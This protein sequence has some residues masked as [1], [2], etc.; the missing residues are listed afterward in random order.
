[1]S[2]RG[3][4]ALLLLA[5]FAAIAVA[6]Q[7]AISLGVLGLA[8]SALGVKK[9]DSVTLDAGVGALQAAARVVDTAWSSPPAR[10][11]ELNPVT[12]GAVDDLRASVH[13]VAVGS[14]TLTPLAEAA[15]LAVG[16]DGE[17]PLLSGSTIDTARLPD[18]A[19][20]VAALHADLQSTSDALAAVPGSGP[21]GW[22]L[23]QVADSAQA[24]TVDLTA[25][26]AAA[27]IA[28]PD[29]PEALGSK[30]PRRYLV[31]ALNDAE[32]FGSG[33]APLFAMVVEAVRGTVSV[34]I[35][36]QLESK[37][38]PNNPPIRWEYAGGPPW[39]RESRKYP[40]VNSNFHPDFRTASLDMERAWAALGYPEVD[41]V[42]TVD[43]TALA[44]ILAWTGPVTSEGFGEVDS[45]NLIQTVLVDAYREFDSPE[46]VLERH[47]RNDALISAIKQSLTSPV[48]VLPAI[49]GTM[50]AIPPRHVQAGFGDGTLQ[51]AVESLGAA[52]ALSSGDGDLIGVFSQSG[53]NKLTVFQ[54]RRISQE[55]R[56]TDDGGAEI[57]RTITFVN[58]VPD[59]LEGDEDS[60]AGYTALRARM[61]VAY[62]IPLSA[63][64]FEISTGTAIPLVK[65]GR[66][67]PYPD[68]RGGQVL[69][70][71]HETAPG[72]ATTVDVRYTLPAGT[73]EPG[74]YEVQA[75]PQALPRD[76]RLELRVIPAP[77]TPIPAQSHNW[78]SHGGMLAWE[79]FLDRTL[80]LEVGR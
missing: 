70:Q 16:F 25:L 7:L 52:G 43:V 11:L 55:V 24:T 56:L 39:Y 36:G 64:D 15:E 45:D 65:T 79:G 76:V 78:T 6:V 37:L 8:Q 2:W 3:W 48:N 66:E 9:R 71:G 61:R 49:R 58:D 32:S 34:P 54:E 59:D 22:P 13:A 73:F 5:P 46:G 40:F 29:L 10:L 28:M 19:D 18:L 1:M 75:D 14:Q 27:Q 30:E 35:S 44:T 77:G 62:R 31:A 69:W 63:T 57:R 68:E 38:S 67:G 4:L 41:G 33:G 53:P 72:A 12:I 23:G 80:H 51:D 42:V 50:R 26:A 47:A 20:P 60:W 17:P 21:F 74:T